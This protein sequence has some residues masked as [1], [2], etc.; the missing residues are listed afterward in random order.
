MSR[1]LGERLDVAGWCFVVPHSARDLSSYVRN[2]LVGEVIAALEG[3]RG[4]A[5]RR[6]RHATTWKVRIAG[7]TGESTNIFVKQL[8]AARGVIAR[9]KAKSRAKRSDH[10]LQI[11]EDLRRHNFGVPSVLLIGEN[12]DTG[13]EVIVMS[14]APGF[15][16]TRWMNPS[17]HIDVM[18][19]RRILH[20]L[21]AEI[22][23]LHLSG[24]IHG[25]LTPYNIVATGDHPIAITF[26]DHEGTE[27]TSRVSIN[28]ARNRMRNLVQ[29]GHFDIPGVSRTDHLRVF[30]SYAA[31]I[32]L[33]K[34]GR[35]QSLLRLAKMIQ[36]R[37]NRDRTIK[38][39]AT[40]PAIIAEEGAARG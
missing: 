1:D 4:T 20:K 38:R 24:Y 16:L 28:V 27:R 23:R 17:R 34:R 22:A 37:R 36:R 21:G 18:L 13:N 9:A 2:E 39:G 25:D 11:S 12:R 29:L 15:M 6:S 26:I 31:A 32:G 7:P 33:S 14:E 30:A 10:V 19:R 40:Q 35:R 5:F 3:T 8:D